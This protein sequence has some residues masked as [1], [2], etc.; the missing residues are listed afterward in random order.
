M[1]VRNTLPRRVM[2]GN[3]RGR[4]GEKLGKNNE[5]LGEMNGKKL[6]A[7]K[8]LKGFLKEVRKDVKQSWKMEREIEKCGRK[9]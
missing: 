1:G 3:W 7:R 4:R 8:E 9:A 5:I 2:I 6:R